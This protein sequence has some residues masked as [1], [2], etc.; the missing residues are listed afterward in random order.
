MSKYLFLVFLRC[1]VKMNPITKREKMNE[2]VKKIIFGSPAFDALYSLG[3]KI[4]QKRLEYIY[5]RDVAKYA[6]YT[7]HRL[8]QEVVKSYARDFKLDTLIETGTYFGDMVY[9]VKNVFSDIFSIELDDILFERANRK[10][11]KYPHIHII[12]GDSGEI[13]PKLLISVSKPSLFWLDAHYSKGITAKAN[14][15]TPVEEEI[16]HIIGAPYFEH[17]ALID[18]AHLFTGQGAYSSLERLKQLVS[19]ARKDWIFEVKDDIIRLHSKLA[20]SVNKVKS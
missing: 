15:E 12:H 6:A 1:Y 19:S 5:E 13:L 2:T 10:F 18:D 8:K 11:S 3:R 4:G 16:R 14:K 17:V 20:D 7:P 9:A